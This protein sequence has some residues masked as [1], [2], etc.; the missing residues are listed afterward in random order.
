MTQEC[1]MDLSCL[2]FPTSV[3]MIMCETNAA[4]TERFS[5]SF[6][7]F[8]C[9]KSP[10]KFPFLATESEK[11]F[12]ESCTDSKISAVPAYIG[13]KF[14]GADIEVLISAAMSCVKNLSSPQWNAQM[15]THAQTH[16]TAHTH[17]QDHTNAAF[18]QAPLD[19][20]VETQGHFISATMSWTKDMSSHDENAV[21]FEIVSTW[22]RNHTWPC[23]AAFTGPDR[24]CDIP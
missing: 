22:R 5:G 14:L 12:F 16:T 8:S 1:K 11:A 17:T 4:K 2:V 19:A 24:R 7:F 6:I 18:L 9:A 13:C 15:R 10:R 23:T 21:I 3:G 20:S